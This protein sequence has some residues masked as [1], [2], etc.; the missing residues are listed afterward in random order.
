MVFSL[1]GKLYKGNIEEI[2]E[3]YIEIKTANFMEQV[4]QAEANLAKPTADTSPAPHQLTPTDEV[5][6]Y[7]EVV[8]P[9]EPK[10]RRVVRT[11]QTGD[12]VY[13]LDMT[14]GTR[15]WVPTPEKL[16]ELGFNFG[17]VENV[18]DH[19]LRAL[20]VVMLPTQ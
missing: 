16:S 3:K 11:K 14:A 13:F 1:G 8:T 18:E 5:P 9:E 2:D 6:V 4:N 19:E 7:D 15:A 20:K 10:L 12:K 17:D